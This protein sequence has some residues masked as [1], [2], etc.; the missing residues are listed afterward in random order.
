[1]RKPSSNGGPA[2][3]F[4]ALARPCLRSVKPFFP[5]KRLADVQRERKLKRVVRLASNENPL[6]ASPR[7]LAELRGAAPE[8][9]RY[10]DCSSPLLRRAFAEA[11][12]LDEAQVIIG[13][14]S[15][16]VLRLLCET[17][18]TPEDEVV[19]SQYA[20]LRF[21][22]HAG[23]LGAKVIEV[24]MVDWTHDLETMGRAA[25]TRTKLVFAANPNNPT[26]TWNTQEEVVRLL[27]SLPPTALL[28]LDEAYGH[29]AAAH[30]GYP[31]SLPGLVRRF[32]NLFVL[33]TFSKAF[34]LAGLRVGAG[35]GDPALIGWLDRVRIPFNVSLPA[36]RAACA[37][38]KD[39]AFLKKSVAACERGRERLAGDL[40][41]LGFSTAD[42]AGNF[43]F[44]ECPVPGHELARGLLHLGVAVH[45]LDEYGLPDH[46]RIS[47]GTDADHR[48]LL[49]AVEGVLSERRD[50]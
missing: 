49:R 29:F 47:V 38:L 44:V 4:D 12:G 45:P 25:S 6:G 36:Q 37:A 8:A 7:A 34:G 13:N 41:R 23:I 42:S 26:G 3:D 21:K 10:P 43:L 14:G 11:H 30:A 1:M 39:A 5:G 46:V 40:R 33:R 19:V 2:V 32:P 24:P 20:Y 27:K 15:D 16:E 50:A 9:H 35:V 28:V 48:E 18:L 31:E 22:Q 17:L